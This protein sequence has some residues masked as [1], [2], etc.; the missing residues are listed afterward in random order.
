M[1]SYTKAQQK[2]SSVTAMTEE[3]YPPLALSII[4]SLFHTI[5]AASGGFVG[6]IETVFVSTHCRVAL[7]R[8][9]APLKNTRQFSDY[10]MER[11]EGKQQLSVACL[12]VLDLPQLTG[13]VKEKL[14]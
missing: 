8:Y 1:F 12:A 6:G 4:M 11:A 7:S 2:T 9:S 13:S 3:K 10:M 5:P 14:H